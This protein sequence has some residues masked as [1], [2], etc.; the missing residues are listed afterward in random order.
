MEGVGAATRGEAQMSKREPEAH[1]FS[2]F[3]ELATKVV[4][5]PKAEALKADKRT[6]ASV[7]EPKKA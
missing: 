5:V 4:N 2:K 7:E 3:K 1:E 6:T